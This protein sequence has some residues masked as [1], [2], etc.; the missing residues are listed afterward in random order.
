M[1][2]IEF[3]TTPIGRHL[4]HAHLNPKNS[5]IRTAVE[6]VHNEQAHLSNLDMDIV[7]N[8]TIKDLP[9]TPVDAI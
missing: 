4:F 7:L 5:F 8:R 9:G 3:R 6:S 2:A 1:A